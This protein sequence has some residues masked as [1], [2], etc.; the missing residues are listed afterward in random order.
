M[1]SLRLRRSVRGLSVERGSRWW[2]GREMVLDLAMSR[3]GRAYRRLLSIISV[4]F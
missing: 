4:S 2:W 1:R 3:W